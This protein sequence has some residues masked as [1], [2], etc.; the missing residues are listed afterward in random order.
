MKKIIHKLLKKCYRLFGI[1]AVFQEIQ[2]NR[3]GLNLNIGAGNY[4]MD[5]FV[6]LDFYTPHYY[7]SRKEFDTNRVHYDMRGEKIPYDDNSVSNI[8]CSHV[9]EHIETEFVESFFR[10]SYRVLVNGG[11]LRTA[12][13]DAK[14]LYDMMM[15]N[16]EDYFIWHPLF[17]RAKG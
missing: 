8:Y 11:C 6:S 9:I 4:E 17:K 16:Y 3:K 2:H 1:H 7:K 13:P 14:F 15:A 10:E 12:C 5:G